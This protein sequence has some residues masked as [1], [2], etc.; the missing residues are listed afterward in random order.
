M[1][2]DVKYLAIDTMD[3]VLLEVEFLTLQFFDLISTH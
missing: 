1:N 2:R 3:A